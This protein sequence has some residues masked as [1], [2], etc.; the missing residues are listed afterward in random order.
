MFQ[1]GKVVSIQAHPTATG[2]GVYVWE[3][4]NAVDRI[5]PKETVY[6][7]VCCI[8]GMEKKYE[9]KN[10]HT[11]WIAIQCTDVRKLWNSHNDNM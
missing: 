11:L 10:A 5:C 9:K 8:K 6:K 7:E 3:I 2:Y 1:L 4:L